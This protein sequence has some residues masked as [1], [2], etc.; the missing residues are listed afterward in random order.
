MIKKKICII[1]EFGAGKTSV[2]S[3]YVE[4]YFS[5]RY[6]TTIGVSIKQKL[7]SYER[8]DV[9]LIIWDIAGDQL[10]SPINLN[11]LRG[12]SG[13]ILV[14][15]ATRPNLQLKSEGMVKMV[16]A[17][18]GRV[19]FVILLNKVDLLSNKEIGELK[20][21]MLDQKHHDFVFSSA[22]TGEGVEAAF[23]NLLSNLLMSEAS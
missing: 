1:G 16:E 7:M 17:K 22:K 19:P 23:N 14:C 10:D 18:V 6:L 15:D 8:Q 11:Y 21:S 2:V 4:N 3:R 20:I 9:C 5:E 12:L 13:Y